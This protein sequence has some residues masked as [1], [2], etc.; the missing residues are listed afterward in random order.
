MEATR[1]RVPWET[2]PWDAAH[3]R[4][5][6]G[7][8]W[9]ARVD[10]KIAAVG[11]L[12]RL[13]PGVRSAWLCVTPLGRAHPVFVIRTLARCL[14]AQIQAA[15][16]RRVQADICD[17]DTAGLALVTRLG[18]EEEGIMRKYGPNGEDYIRCAR[19]TP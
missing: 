3:D 2:S 12:L 11:G 16:L 6:Q 10:D 8:A 14:V 1:G 17:H 13:W 15:E 18:F 9:T 4:L 19:I 5:E 7:D